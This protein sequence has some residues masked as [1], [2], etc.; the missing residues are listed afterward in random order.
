MKDKMTIF[1]IN[2]IVKNSNYSVGEIAKAAGM[3]E[4]QLRT[5]MN[6]RV[7]PLEQYS[8]LVEAFTK[9]GEIELAEQLLLQFS[10]LDWCFYYLNKGNG[11]EPDPNKILRELSILQGKINN[12][13]ENLE[14]LDQYKKMHAL[15]HIQN[16]ISLLHDLIRLID[17]ENRFLRLFT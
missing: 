8:T 2:Q 11:A 1:K 7:P 5:Y 10:G 3:S 15:I 17:R 13:F 6:T 14:D 9:L 16:T 4:S 12:I